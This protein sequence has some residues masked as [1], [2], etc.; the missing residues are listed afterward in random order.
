M[1]S[2]PFLTPVLVHIFY[3]NNG[4]FYFCNKYINR[5]II[6][7]RKITAKIPQQIKTIHN[8]QELQ[9]IKF[10]NTGDY[11]CCLINDKIYNILK[12]NKAIE[13]KYTNFIEFYAIKC[14]IS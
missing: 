12:T 8:C 1:I 13:T 9:E 6:F 11:I 5:Y 4:N 14:N 10:I 3:H 2:N 7:N